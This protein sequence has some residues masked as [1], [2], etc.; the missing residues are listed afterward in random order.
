MHSQPGRFL[1]SSAESTV[2]NLSYMNAK[3]EMTA[4]EVLEEIP[5]HQT[6][7]VT[8]M[9]PIAEDLVCGSEGT[10]GTVSYTNSYLN[11]NHILETDALLN[12]F[13]VSYNELNNLTNNSTHCS[14]P[15]LS[16]TSGWGLEKY[17]DNKNCNGSAFC[18]ADVND[19]MR[20]DVF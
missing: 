9:Y 6:P 5:Q 3:N 16:S 20:S 11:E 10:I 12:G 18:R 17:D 1:P 15:L 13:G 19:G 8:L 4:S 2:N 7:A 14:V